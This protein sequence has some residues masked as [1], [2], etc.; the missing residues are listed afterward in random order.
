MFQEFY[1]FRV[2]PF[3][4]NIPTS[5]LFCQRRMKMLRFRRRKCYTPLGQ[6]ALSWLG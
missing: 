1:G 2:M 3:S 4:R 5:D 6:P